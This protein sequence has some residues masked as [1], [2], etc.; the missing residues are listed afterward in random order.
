LNGNPNSTWNISGNLIYPH[1]IF[2]TNTN[3][4]YID[5]G[6]ANGRIEK[7][8]LNATNSTTVMYVNE[9]CYSLFI[10]IHDN[11]YCSLKNSHK[12]I[13]KS[14]HTNANT[15]V[16]VAGNG[17]NG[18]ASNMLNM[19][20]GIFIDIAVNLYVAD[21]GNDRV[22][23]MKSGEMNGTTINTNTITLSCPTGV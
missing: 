1:G 2:V 15:T 11:L 18:S 7:W 22:Q 13:K 16:T 4:I 9:S 3:D 5:N 19:P 17:I 20:C 14:L 10:D 12:V 6:Y 8:K 21:C 23:L